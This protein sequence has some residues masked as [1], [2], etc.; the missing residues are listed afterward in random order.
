MQN[1]KVPK[2]MK[3]YQGDL[4][5]HVKLS[6][7]VAVDTETMGLKHDRDRLCLV[8]LCDTERNCYL[9]QIAPEQTEAANLKRI[10]EDETILKIFHF[11]RFD[12]VALKRWLGISCLP[13]YCTRTVSKLVRTYSD[14]HGLRDLCNE[15]LRIDIDKQKQSSNWGAESLSQAQLSY[16]YSD[17]LHLHRL[18]DELDNRLEREGRTALAEACFAFLPMRAELDLHG[19]DDLD[20]FAH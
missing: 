14:R 18:K 11:A 3:L 6:G 7:S 16:A 9:V 2:S 20:I 4:P 1:P 12:L 15:L 13:L 10:L 8:Q 5:A 19:W 17:V